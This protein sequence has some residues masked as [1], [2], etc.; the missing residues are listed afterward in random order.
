MSSFPSNITVTDSFTGKVH[1]VDGPFL[2]CRQKIVGIFTD[3]I[4]SVTSD[5]DGN[6]SS[7][8]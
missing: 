6:T 1:S 8:T 4:Y 5:L 7:R 2:G 3:T